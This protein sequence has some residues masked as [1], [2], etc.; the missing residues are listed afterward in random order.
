MLGM[1]VLLSPLLQ[2][3]FCT[4]LLLQVGKLKGCKDITGLVVGKI[5][6]VVLSVSL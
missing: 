3:Q 6:E 2:A 4:L 5:A 1:H